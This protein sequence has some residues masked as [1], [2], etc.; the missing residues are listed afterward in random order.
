MDEPLA[1]S[2]SAARNSGRSISSERAGVLGDTCRAASPAGKKS[3]CLLSASV[4]DRARLDAVSVRRNR[5]GVPRRLQQ[6]AARRA[7]PPPGGPGGASAASAAQ[8]QH[9]LFARQREPL[10]RA[11]DGAVARS[12]ARLFF[13]EFRQR[14]QR[15]GVT[16]GTHTYGQRR[17]HRSRTRL[18]RPHQHAD[19]HQPVQI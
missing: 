19:R 7:Q 12:A 5:P 18:P 9:A 2:K 6:R 13:C 15:I 17:R 4:E 11:S 1:Q 16:S 8:H 3:E 10:C 14:S